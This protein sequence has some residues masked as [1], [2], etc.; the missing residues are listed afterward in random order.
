[1]AQTFLQTLWGRELN[2]A[3]E[4]LG[5]PI[6]RSETVAREKPDLGTLALAGIK[7]QALNAEFLAVE[8]KYNAGAGRF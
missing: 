4:I 3:S 5:Q 7:G 2:E 8:I 1:M 6:S